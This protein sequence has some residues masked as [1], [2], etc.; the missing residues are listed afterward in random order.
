MSD[1]DEI[2]F[3]SLSDGVFAWTAEVGWAP[4][5]AEGNTS[6]SILA[7]RVDETETLTQQDGWAISATHDFANEGEYGRFR[8]LHLG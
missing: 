3:S 5:S 8:A 2:D 4:R 6:V 7:F 1:L